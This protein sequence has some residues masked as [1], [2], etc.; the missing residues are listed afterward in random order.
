MK[1]RAW[2][3]IISFLVIFSIC[4]IFKLI[5]IS[6]FLAL[7]G[8]WIL[9]F[10]IYMVGPETVSEIT[11]WKSSIKRDVTAAREIREE[12]EKISD[13]LKSVIELSAENSYILAQS[14]VSFG[15]GANETAKERLIDNIDK[16]IPYFIKN[17]IPPENWWK[18]MRS[19]AFPELDKDTN[20]NEA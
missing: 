15:M 2:F 20:A 11:I 10:F 7:S 5:D 6:G 19:Q 12:I 8:V 1:N 16:L 13:N 3:L 14:N 9:G 4:Y 18:I 17:Q